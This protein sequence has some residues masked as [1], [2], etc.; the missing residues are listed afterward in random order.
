M[1]W[2]DKTRKFERKSPKPPPIIN[3]KVSLMNEVHKDFGIHCIKKP[4]KDIEAIADTGC[5]TTT[6]GIDTLRKMNIPDQ[7]LI[8]TNHGIVG[9]TDT[10]LN[11]LG[12]LMLKMTYNGSET[13]QMV[14]V[15]SN[16]MGLYLSEKA[17]SDLNL[18]DAKFPNTHI[19]KS[20]SASVRTEKDDCEC[21]PREKAPEPPEKIPYPP[22]PENKNKL[23]S[24]LIKR[25][26]SSAFNTCTH[27]P[28]QE[29]TG[30]P[31]KI[32]FKDNYEPHAVHT[33]IP[34]PY[35]WED[36]VDADIDRDVRLDILEKVPE[37]TPVTWCSR[38]VVQAKK[39]GKPR[40]TVDLQKLNNATRRETHYTP[41]PFEIVSTIPT[42]TYKTVLD[43]W[44]GYHSMPLAEESRDATTFITKRGRYR[45]KRAPQGFHAS[46]DAYTHRFDNITKDFDRV[47]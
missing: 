16:P 37:G 9:I 40:R 36:D 10:R 3:V 26:E 45:Y 33:P 22:I 43:A 4:D 6:C 47:K 21:I 14:Y 29:M 23:K 27:Q 25:F 8:P 30:P 17:L 12:T 31:M 39:N 13:R 24:W 20:L 38:M 19:P 1:E 46:G 7:C 44:N 18:I 11:I 35:H 34:Y 5:Q 2:N 42:N 15:S 32:H 41:T 28:L